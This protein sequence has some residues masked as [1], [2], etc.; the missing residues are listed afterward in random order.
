MPIRTTPLLALAFFSLSLSACFG[1]S[2]TMKPTPEKTRSFD[3]IELFTPEALAWPEAAWPRQGSLSFYFRV[4]GFEDSR[5]LD[6]EKG[7]YLGTKFLRGPAFDL[8]L[9]FTE[10]GAGGL[11]LITRQEGGGEKRFTLPIIHLR[12]GQTYHVALNWDLDAKDFSAHFNGIDQGDLGHWGDETRLLLDPDEPTVLD[13]GFAKD[14]TVRLWL[15]ALTL[16]ENQ[17]L[18]DSATLG[19][20][21]PLRTEGR[22]TYGDTPM[23]LS[24]YRTELLYA[25]DFAEPQ[26]IVHESQLFD[27]GKRVRLPEGDDTWVLEGPE[28]LTLETRPDGLHMET[29]DPEDRK[30]GHWVLWLNREFPDDILVEYSFTP[31]STRQ[32][33]N[34]LFF[35]AHNPEG[36]SIFD[37]DLPYRGGNFREYIIGAINSY[38][39]SPWA[40]DSENLRATSNMR[41]NAGFHLVARGNDVIGGAED[42]PH[43]VRI[44]KSGGTIR[45]E[46]DG[47][48]CL[49]FDD[50]GQTYGPVYGGG[51]IGIRF[52]AHT[53][54][55]TLHSLK[56]YALE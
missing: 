12:G 41:K 8:Q 39:I 11:A 23:D 32:G 47:V 55:A 44:L 45:M 52:M 37:L 27:D 51:A 22:V 35:A 48:L 13:G 21:P 9:Y 6:L 34:I 36:D 15:G 30:N 40:T 54:S 26:N 31:E 18:P 42:G 43:T 4:E 49:T 24:D 38:H 3:G 20:I 53:G 29:P 19:T 33:L 28:A 10:K 17:R 50:D 16:D 2:Q 56:V 7:E 46:A 5:Q 14:P 1:E 25:V